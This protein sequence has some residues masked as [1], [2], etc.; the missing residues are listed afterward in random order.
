M[1][2]HTQVLR[3]QLTKTILDLLADGKSVNVFGEEGQGL[4]RLVDDLVKLKPADAQ[5]VRLSMKSYAHS[6]SGFAADLRR[7]LGSAAVENSDESI[8]TAVNR[9]VE[10]PNVSILWLVIEHFDRLTEKPAANESVDTEGYN[11]AFLDYLNSFR[12]N[13]K[14]RLLFTSTHQIKTQELY[15][16]GARVSG[17]RLE[18]SAYKD[19]PPLLSEDIKAELGWRCAFVAPPYWE[20]PEGLYLWGILNAHPQ[21]YLFLDFVAD[22]LEPSDKTDFKTFEQLIAKWKSD[23]DKQ[24]A[25]NLDKRLGHLEAWS[26]RFL[27]RTTRFLGISK[28]W[29]KI[30]TKIGRI[31]V[32]LAGFGALAY[33]W[34]EK[35][36]NFVMAFFSK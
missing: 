17:S 29:K 22:R 36:Y 13:T 19:L 3:P 7:Q 5:L 20:S 4:N 25:P 1:M 10:R 6:Y 12:N 9:F 21:A 18:L 16:G 28:I 31:A 34:G 30:N 15:V 8:A 11:R 33:S 24:N 26:N 35:M 14:I 23:F 2:N 27:E 32:I